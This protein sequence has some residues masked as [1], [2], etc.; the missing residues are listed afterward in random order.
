LSSRCTNADS[1]INGVCPWKCV[2]VTFICN[3]MQPTLW[4]ELTII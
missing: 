2:G 1:F 3:I 4:E